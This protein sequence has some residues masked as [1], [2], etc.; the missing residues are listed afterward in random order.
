MIR[1]E[2]FLIMTG[3]TLK[4][5]IL[6]FHYFKK[7]RFALVILLVIAITCVIATHL[8]SHAQKTGFEK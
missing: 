7:Y 8:K 2:S 6:I 4:L 3:K 5:T 1:N